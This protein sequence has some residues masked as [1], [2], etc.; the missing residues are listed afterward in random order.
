MP[1]LGVECAT[2]AHAQCSERAG[3]CRCPCHAHTQALLRKGNPKPDRK[4]GIRRKVKMPQVPAV[5]VPQTFLAEAESVETELHNTCPKC[6]K[7]FRPTDQFCRDDGTKLCLGKPCPRC[8]AP[9]DE[10]DSYCNQCG[11]RLSEIPP[12]TI[13]VS[14]ELAE[15]LQ[16]QLASEREDPLLR[17]RREAQEK[18]LL[19]RETVVS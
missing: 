14:A 11:W 15:S 7:K 17:I 5:P 10:P 8:E 12:K 13:E 9:C 4:G 6:R 18:G 3:E 16:E 1:G 2:G 19:P